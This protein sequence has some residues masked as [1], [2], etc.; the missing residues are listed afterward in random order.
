MRKPKSLF[1]W[2]MLDPTN[3][4]I[5][6][7][8]PGFCQGLSAHVQRLAKEREAEWKRNTGDSQDGA[9]KRALLRKDLWIVEESSD[10]NCL[11][12]AVS[13]QL[14]GHPGLHATVRKN[15]ELDSL[16]I[17]TAV[18]VV[19]FLFGGIANRGKGVDRSFPSCC[20][21]CCNTCLS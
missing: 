5:S 18:V 14:F 19:N 9:F 12:R 13:R 16:H 20:Y 1:S 17:R 4:T 11:Y 7:L 21:Y 10:G 6:P 15:W 8:S 3:V 2:K